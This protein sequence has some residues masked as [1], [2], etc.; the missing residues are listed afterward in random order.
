ML[1]FIGKEVIDVIE[2]SL[3]NAEP[4]LEALVL[5]QMDKLA[6]VIKSW[7]ATRIESKTPEKDS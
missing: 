3:V 1:E 6:T 4:E 5:A 7:I 2:K